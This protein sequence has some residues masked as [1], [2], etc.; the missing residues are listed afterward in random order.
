MHVKTK[1]YD[2]R[3]LFLTCFEVD[4]K[5]TLDFAIKALSLHPNN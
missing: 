5:K 1:K 4:T 3:A 2:E